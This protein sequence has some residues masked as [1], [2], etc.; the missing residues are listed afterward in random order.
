MAETFKSSGRRVREKWFEQYAPDHLVGID[1]GCQHDPLNHTFRR[2]DLIFGDG[3]ATFMEGVPDSSFYTVYASHVLEHVADPV[4][5]VKNWYR[6]L[7]P[8]GHLIINVPH[9]DLYEK[10][11]LLPSRW[12]GEHK[13]FWLPENHEPPCT[14]GLRQTVLEA[15]PEANIVLLRVLDEGFRDPGPEQHSDGEYS[16]E[17]IVKKPALD[18]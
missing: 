4:L 12:N 8:G 9:R 5:A 15:I 2:W 1:I 6:I 3:D 18:M 16:I 13:T 17:V 10:K 7:R 11:Y 14:R